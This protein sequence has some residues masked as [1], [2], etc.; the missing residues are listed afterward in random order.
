M[1]VHV[2]RQQGRRKGNPRGTG[3]RVCSVCG[4]R[5][6]YASETVRRVELRDRERTSARFF[7]EGAVVCD[8]CLEQNPEH[9]YSVRPLPTPATEGGPCRR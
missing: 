9:E 5:C 8:P 7:N 1:R 4:K 6:Q 2:H 3:Y